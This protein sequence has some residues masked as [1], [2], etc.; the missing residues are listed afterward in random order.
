MILQLKRFLMLIFAFIALSG[1]ALFQDPEDETKGWS[2]KQLL[3]TAKA[4]LLAGDYESAI[5]Y[6]EILQTRYS[7]GRFDQQAQLDLLYAYYKFEEPESAIVE[8]DRFIKLFPRHPHVDYAYYIKGLANFN[9]NYD[10]LQRYL[11]ID[12]SQRDQE[13]ARESFENFAVL[14][15]LFPQS[16]YAEDARQRMVYLRNNQAKHE[17]H[18]A[19]FYLRRGAHLAALNRAKYVV[20]NFSRTPAVPE[21]LAMMVK[22]YKILGYGDLATQSLAV[23]KLNYPEYAGITEVENMAVSE[24]PESNLDTDIETNTGTDS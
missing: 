17:L 4:S 20:E 24:T 11:P 22:M 12:L 6:Y 10:T 1:C 14:V 5:T 21:A 23:L 16:R 8:A 9:R 18:V 19:D 13:T 2:A 7:L 15:R 3:S